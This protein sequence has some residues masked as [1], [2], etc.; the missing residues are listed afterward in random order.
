MNTATA[1][2][3]ANYLFPDDFSHLFAQVC[4]TSE[5]TLKQLQALKAAVSS[6]TLEP[7]ELSCIHRLF[8]ALRRGRIKLS[9]A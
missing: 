7:E 5:L 6:S 3:Q 1:T 9:L 8:Y 4:S 2:P